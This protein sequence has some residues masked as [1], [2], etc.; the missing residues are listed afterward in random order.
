MAS[1]DSYIRKPNQ[2]IPLTKEQ[3]LEFARIMKRPN[4]VKRFVHY[5]DINT[6]DGPKN[7]GTVIKPFQY[8]MID[9][10]QSNDR[11][12]LLASRQMS[13]CVTGDTNITIR[14]DKTGEEMEITMEEFHNLIKN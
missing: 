11:A 4:G 6:A 7:F 14:N 9:L 12:I 10:M 2:V 3:T 13:K 5:V 1:A 8:D